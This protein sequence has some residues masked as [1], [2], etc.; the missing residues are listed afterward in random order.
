MTRSTFGGLCLTLLALMPG[1]S[2]AAQQGQKIAY[3]DSRQV[4][5]AM[6]GYAPAESTYN[7]EVEGFR[8]E[9]EAMQGALDSAAAEFDQQSVML[10]PTARASKRKELEA[11]RDKLEKR[12][13]ELREKAVTR[14]RDLLEPLH[15][16]VNQALDAVRAEGN[17]ALIFDVSANSGIIVAADKSLDLTS[18]V[19]ERLKARP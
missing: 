15:N 5:A 6:P 9:V 11:Q 4:L 12:A 16:R 14:E 1:A 2:L 7:K 10:S 18:K 17:Y 13:A 8:Q 19:V 3:I